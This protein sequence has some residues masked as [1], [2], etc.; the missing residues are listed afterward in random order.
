VLSGSRF[1]PGS[2]F[3]EWHQKSGKK[4]NSRL[5]PFLSTLADAILDRLVHSA[6]K[7]K[8]NGESM[9]KKNANLT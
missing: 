6:H 1:L 8:L 5:D 7:I 3:S 9:R 2:N 4:A